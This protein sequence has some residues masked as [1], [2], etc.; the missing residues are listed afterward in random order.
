MGREPLSGSRRLNRNH[1]DR[2]G[3][4]LN[5]TVDKQNRL[6]GR[7]LFCQLG[8]PLLPCDHPHFGAVGE[9]AL[10]P[11]RKKRPDTVIPAQRVTAGENEASGRSQAHGWS[12]D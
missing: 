3:R 9:A 11:L 2:P 4:G 12:D 1:L 7:N 6:G 5:G 8:R 10:S